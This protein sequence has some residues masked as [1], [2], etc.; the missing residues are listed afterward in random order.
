MPSLCSKPKKPIKA[1]LMDGHSILCRS[2]DS[3]NS[4]FDAFNKVRASRK[5][6]GTPTDHEQDLLRAS[7]LF[8]A[9]GLDAMAKQLIRDALELTHK[10]EIGSHQEFSNY[11]QSRLMKG[12][13]LDI[14]YVTQAL[15]ADHP[16]T[17]LREE[18]VRELTSNSL[19]SKDQLLRVAS[20][21]AIPADEVVSDLKKL[22]N[23]FDA[24]NQ[25]AHEMDVLLGQTN[26]SR[27]PRTYET[28]QDY[29][30]FI[31]HVSCS[32]YSAVAKRV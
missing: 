21:F 20:Y 17:F 26:R 9:A 27:R 3:A 30:S 8:A 19:Q 7:L 13:S 25:I 10:K 5:A 31:L 12:T 6:K 16:K 22:K 4:F 11:V 18:L 15:L 29:T 28:M 24:R 14:K 1:A 2:I 32:F 23:V